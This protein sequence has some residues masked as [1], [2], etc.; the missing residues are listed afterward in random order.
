MDKEKSLNFAIRGDIL[1]YVI[2]GLVLLMAGIWFGMGLESDPEIEEIDFPSATIY[3]IPVSL[4]QFTLTDHNGQKFNQWSLARKWT[5]MFFGYT[6]CPDVCPVA[7]VD[8]NDIYHNLLEKGDLDEKKFK[9]NTQVVFVTVDPGRDTVEELKEYMPHFNEAFIGVTGSKEE[10]D[11]LA[12]PMG[13]AYRRVPGEDSEGDYLVDHSASFLLID[14]LGRLRA[15]FSPPHDPK[16]IAEDFRNIR[17]EYTAECCIT[18]DKE[19]KTVIFDYR[20]EKK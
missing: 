17:S 18:S 11:L 15:S 10:I 12:R 2:T 7:L 9:V 1:R 5:F 19:F 6:F 3:E 8:L 14:P 13:V 20:E 4:P 16:Q